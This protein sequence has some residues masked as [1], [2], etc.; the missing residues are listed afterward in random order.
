MPRGYNRPPYI[1]PFDHRDSFET[2]LF[3]WKPPLSAAQTAE[4]AAQV[5]GFTG[6]Q[7]G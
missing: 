4:I 5:P 7:E 6:W 2:K 3:G 1:L